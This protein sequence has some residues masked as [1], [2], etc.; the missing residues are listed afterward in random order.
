MNS[1]NMKLQV[2]RLA[3]WAMVVGVLSPVAVFAAGESR[4]KDLA[5]LEGT[6]M[7][8]LVGYGLIVGL[9][10]TGD[11]PS[12]ENTANSIATMLKSWM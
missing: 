3:L 1:R 7:E 2:L 12:A 4:I 6:T 5:F 11:S 8:P 10:G 9:N